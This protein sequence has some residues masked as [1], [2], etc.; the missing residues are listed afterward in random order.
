MLVSIFLAKVFGVYLVVAGLSILINSQQV[1]SLVKDLNKNTGIIW[2]FGFFTLILGLIA[3][4]FHNVWVADW[5]VVV[6]I[7]AWITLLKGVTII[8]IPDFIHTLTSK[9]HLNFFK[10]SGLLSLLLG[11]YLSYYGFIV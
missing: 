1:A 8:L 11:L 10:I 5:Q 3:V 9:L 4:L 6:T 7:L 2:M